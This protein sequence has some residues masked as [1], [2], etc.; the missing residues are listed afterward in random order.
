[1]GPITI[2]I[3]SE[4]LSLIMLG[5]KRILPRLRY[6]KFKNLRSG[7]TVTFQSGQL[8]QT[9]KIAASVPYDSFE[10]M[11]LHENFSSIFPLA[12]SKEDTLQILQSTYRDDKNIGIVAL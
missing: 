9:C 12:S 7:D 4:L 8:S 3:K 1:M 10:S 11:L 6:G 2:N 5:R